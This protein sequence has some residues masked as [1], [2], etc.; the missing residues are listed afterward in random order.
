MQATATQVPPQLRAVAAHTL[1]PCLS[2]P[3]AL[4]QSDNNISEL[5]ERVSIGGS[6]V[7][8]NAGRAVKLL[9][10]LARGLGSVAGASPAPE[11]PRSAGRQHSTTLPPLSS[12]SV[13]GEHAV[14]RAICQARVACSHSLVAGVAYH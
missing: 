10:K 6:R 13:A 14:W 7:V 5:M 1:S 4:L 11:A 8:Q 9:G 2:G 3:A 12:S